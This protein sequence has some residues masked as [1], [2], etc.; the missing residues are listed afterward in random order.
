MIRKILV[1]IDG[2]DHARKAIEFAS[3]MA[4]KYNSSIYLIHVVHEPKVPEAFIK[5]MRDEHIEEPPAYVY[6]KTVGEKITGG[7][8]KDVKARGIREVH[9]VVD[10]GDPAERIIEYGKKGDFDLIV[11][12]SRGLGALRDLV[13][14]SVSHKVCHLAKCTC[15]TVR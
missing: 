4:L 2:S 12:G 7:A 9:T 14:G 11:I 15:V 10:Q 8:E 3:D 5:Y 13:L 6:L 1:A